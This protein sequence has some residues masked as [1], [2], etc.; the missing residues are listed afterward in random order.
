MARS[1]NSDHVRFRYG[2]CLNEKCSKCNS[3]EVQTVSARKDFVCSE[4][5]KPLRECPPPK[6]SNNKLILIIVA[7]VVVLSGAGF[8]IYK[9]TQS[10]LPAVEQGPVGD[11]ETDG[12]AAD[13]TNVQNPAPVD[14]VE[15]VDTLEPKKTPKKPETKKPITGYGTVNLGYGI[16]TGDL[17]NGVPHGHG[18]IKYTERRKIVNSKDFVA[19]PGDE[20]EADFRDGRVSGSIGYWYHDGNQTAIK[21]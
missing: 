9:Y 12:G 15:A 13:S 16:Y 2:M 5:G 6:S 14:T 4:C 7:A 3:K 8:G 20:F 11:G 18:T 1:T 17:K 19:N 21:P 10:P